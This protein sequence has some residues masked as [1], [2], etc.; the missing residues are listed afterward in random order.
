MNS[1]TSPPL[2]S[3]PSPARPAPLD[4]LR[5]PLQGSRLIEA[6]AGTGK[7]FTIATLYV[8]LVLGHRPAPARM[9]AR[10]SQ[11][12]PKPWLNQPQMWPPTPGLTPPEIL[13]VTF[14]EAA[15]QELRDRIRSR[16]TEAAGYFRAEAARVPARPAGEDPLHDLRLEYPRSNGPVAPTGCNWPPSGWTR[17]RSPPS[18]PGATACCA[19]TPSTAAASSPRPWR[20]TRANCAP[21][22][23][24]TTGAPSWCPSPPEPSPRSAPG[25]RTRRPWSRTCRAWSIMRI[26]WTGAEP[27][28]AIETARKERLRLAEIKAP[29]A[30]WVDELQPCSDAV[31]AKRVNGHKLQARFY[32]P[33]L[34]ALRAWAT[35]PQAVW[36]GAG[37][38]DSA[39]WM[40]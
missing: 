38:E 12:R 34:Q 27:A 17:R 24:A 7:T 14:T 33:W 5:F 8:R 19:S 3:A 29:W 15:T 35:D 31:A 11:G 26:G 2:P 36:P 40:R 13:V 18:M 4:P 25:G 20:P 21:R 22:W 39:A 6:S 1:M 16:L 23:C 32:T 30:G 28:A 10:I 37:S 9:S